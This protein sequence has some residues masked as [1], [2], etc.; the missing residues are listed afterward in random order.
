MSFAKDFTYSLL[1]QKLLLHL[2]PTGEE[3]GAQKFC[4]IP[5]SKKVI[6]VLML[7]SHSPLSNF[8]RVGSFYSS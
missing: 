1:F 2:Y 7:M 3:T 5:F 4:M 6:R 8:N